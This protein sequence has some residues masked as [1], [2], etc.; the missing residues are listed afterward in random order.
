MNNSKINIKDYGIMILKKD[1]ILYHTSDNSLLD[2]NNKNIDFLFC[3]FHPYDYEGINSK[4]VNIIKLKKDIKLFFMV[5]EL[6]IN[7]SNK[8]IHS[9]FSNFFNKDK[10]NLSIINNNKITEFANKLNHTKLDGWFSSIEDKSGIEVAL[11]NN[12]NLYECIGANNF[13]SNWNFIYENNNNKS[14]INIGKKYKICTNEEPAILIINEKFKNNIEK[15]KKRISSENFI[16]TT[17][18]EIVLY[19][20]IILYFDKNNQTQ[21]INNII[22]KYLK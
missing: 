15:Y 12:K 10:K 3:S 5:S 20:A 14:Y 21:N 22:N 18:V 4:Y 7:K 11:L 16:P 8:R 9:A 1:S 6:K 19:N 17:I 2:I 13:N